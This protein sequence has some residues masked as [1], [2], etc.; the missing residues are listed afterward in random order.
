MRFL[1]KA[2]SMWATL[3]DRWQVK[4]SSE[5]Q[6]I[7]NRKI[8]IP[9]NE[10]SGKSLKETPTQN[11]NRPFGGTHVRST[12]EVGDRQESGYWPSGN[13]SS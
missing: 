9:V 11:L 5:D 8:G 10:G 12:E 4:G 13:Q 1:D 7:E 6:H 3:E 2:D